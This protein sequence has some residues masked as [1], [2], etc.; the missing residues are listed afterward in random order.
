MSG[1]GKAPVEENGKIRKKFENVRQR[2]RKVNVDILHK[3]PESYTLQHYVTV[4]DTGEKG[5]FLMDELERLKTGDN[6]PVFK[7]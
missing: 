1:S 6:S 3:K 4:P 7:W 2:L 5:C